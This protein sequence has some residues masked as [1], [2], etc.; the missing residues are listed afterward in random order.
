MRNPKRRK[1]GVCLERIKKQIFS[2]CHNDLYKRVDNESYPEAYLEP[3]QRSMM[4]LFS[5][6]N[7]AWKPHF[8]KKAL[9]IY[10]WQGSQYTSGIQ[11]SIQ[12]LRALPQTKLLGA[13]GEY[14]FIISNTHWENKK[15]VFRSNKFFLHPLA[16]KQKHYFYGHR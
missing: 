10:I 12:F 1:C 9:I 13:R 16:Q 8:H 3:S 2:K 14:S 6:R 11:F 4:K 15:N 7:N 5:E